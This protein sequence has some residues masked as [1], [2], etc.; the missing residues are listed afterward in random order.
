MYV[1]TYIDVLC[2][3][4]YSDILLFLCIYVLAVDPLLNNA[5]TLHTQNDNVT[6]A[7]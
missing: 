3:K 7:A 2:F 4:K 1:Y 6:V 5:L